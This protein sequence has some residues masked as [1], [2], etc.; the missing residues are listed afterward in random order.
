MAPAAMQALPA[1]RDPTLPLDCSD[2][3]LVCAAKHPMPLGTDSY[4]VAILLHPDPVAAITMSAT[5]QSHVY[6]SSKGAGASSK[7]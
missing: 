5:G 6:L 1:R 7:R 2:G 3:A 4:A